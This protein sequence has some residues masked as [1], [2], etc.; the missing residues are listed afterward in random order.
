MY[1][2]SRLTKKGD[3][4]FYA[5]AACAAAGDGVSKPSDTATAGYLSAENNTV[6]GGSEVI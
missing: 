4:S 6:D 2:S 5:A 3:I 1:C